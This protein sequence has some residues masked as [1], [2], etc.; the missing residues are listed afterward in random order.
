[1]YIIPLLGVL[2][3]LILSPSSLYTVFSFLSW[4]KEHT[5]DWWEKCL[6]CVLRGVEI[7]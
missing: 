3:I 2:H 6:H 4:E 5:L 1:M 7:I